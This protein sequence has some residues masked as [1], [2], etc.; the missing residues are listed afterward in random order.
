MV[1]RVTN[2]ISFSQ[3]IL[4]D[5]ALMVD[6]HLSDRRMFISSTGI[7][8]H[9]LHGQDWRCCTQKEII[10]CIP[11]LID[12]G[13]VSSFYFCQKQHRL[14]NKLHRL[15]ALN[16]QFIHTVP[17]KFSSDP[18][19]QFGTRGIHGEKKSCGEKSLNITGAAL[20]V[21]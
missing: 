14:I 16:F 5:L 1:R 21:S 19:L 12:Y 11:S 13:F 10:H 15:N 2:G 17:R 20:N 4:Y 8:L 3:D 9:R 6:I 7:H 18:A